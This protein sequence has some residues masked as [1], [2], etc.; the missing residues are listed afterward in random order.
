MPVIVILSVGLNP[1]LLETRKVVLGAAGY[2]VESAMSVGG[3]GARFAGGDFDLVLLCRSL[4]AEDRELLAGLVRTSGSTIPVVTVGRGR[5]PS[6]A[7]RDGAKV[8]ELTIEGGMKELLGAVEKIIGKRRAMGLLP[9]ADG[10]TGGAARPKP[11][12][13]CVDDEPDALLLRR[14]LL[15][16]AGYRVLTAGDG[17]EALKVFSTGV[18]DAAV[19]DYTMPGMN[20]GEVAAKMRFLNPAVPLMLHSGSG[21]IPQE[22]EELFDRVVPKGG[23]PK[24]LLAAIE[25]VLESGAKKAPARFSERRLASDSLHGL[26]QVGTRHAAEGGDETEG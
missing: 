12:V 19:L 4:P 17:P 13:L 3:A 26:K 8:G 25:Q 11:T 21:V 2:I 6:V 18:M 5:G 15:E 16:G 14:K 7:T 24:L 22:T 20:G 23:F 1:V 10:A 9:G